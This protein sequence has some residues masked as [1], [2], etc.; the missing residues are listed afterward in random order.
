MLQHRCS[1]SADKPVELR[2]QLKAC[3][4]GQ[5]NFRLLR[6]AAGQRGGRRRPAEGQ[7]SKL[8]QL[9][10]KRANTVSRNPEVVVEK[11]L[12]QAMY[13]YQGGALLSPTSIPTGQLLLTLVLTQGPSL[14]LKTVL[15]KVLCSSPEH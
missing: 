1:Q 8:R 4:S 11:E 15:M 7:K 3:T 10:S 5:V 13:D 9:R 14:G 6:V 12:I 2:A